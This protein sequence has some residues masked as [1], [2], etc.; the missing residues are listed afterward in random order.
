MNN[1]VN[2]CKQEDYDIA[3]L[4]QFVLDSIS[5]LGVKG[6]KAGST[7]LVK[8][9]LPYL[10]KVND[11]NTTNP[12]LVAAVVNVVSNM[13]AKCIV[14]D[15]PFG[16]FNETNMD[17]VYFSTGMLEVAN[18]TKCELNSDFSSVNLAIP[19]GVRTHSLPII[20]IAQKVDCIINLAKLKIDAQLGYCGALSNLFGL[21]PGQTKN[22]YLNRQNTL[23]DFYNLLI[24]LYETMSDKIVLNIVDGV[25]AR[26]VDGT[27]NLLSVLASSTNAYAI[28]SQMLKI[29]GIQQEN[30]VIKLAIDRQIVKE[31]NLY[32][33]MGESELNFANADF[34]PT[35][36]KL[37]SKLKDGISNKI[38][39]NMHQQRVVIPC[40]KC[41]GCGVC[42]ELCPAKAI[43]MKF[44]KS[45]ELF[46]EV[47][48]KKCIYCNMCYLKCPYKV[49]SLNT[50]IG[51]K[52]IVKQLE[53]SKE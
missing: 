53:N 34:L 47:D 29:V 48:Y 20:S 52:Q 15:S 35:E 4:E 9:N 21:L 50:P 5:R 44:D 17:K 33:A 24:D 16:N 37:D 23:K 32:H 45:G 31:S 1:F 30:S 13:G 51:Y 49:I 19:D 27:P 46:A 3:S 2:L 22:L 11:A 38:Y 26:Q 10:S 41:K 39:F 6:L 18:T 28:D 8:V 42:A 40:K 7:V 36:I 12:N 25:V 14:A 43:T